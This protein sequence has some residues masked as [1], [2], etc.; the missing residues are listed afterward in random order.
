MTTKP[1]TNAEHSAHTR[2]LLIKAGRQEFS[3]W[4]YAEASTERIVE[5]AGV[6]RGALYHHYRDKRELFEAVVTELQ[7][8]IVR[9]I[10]QRATARRDVFAGLLAGCDAWLDACLD[11]EVRRILLLD[12]PAVLG[13]ERWTEIDAEHGG[14]SLR[15]GIDACIEA[16]EL[17][18]VDAASLTHLLTGAMNHAALLMARSDDVARLR[19]E[20]GRTL[21]A[22]L[23]G[24][25][26]PRD[27]ARTTRQR[28]YSGGSRGSTTS[29][30]TRRTRRRP[31]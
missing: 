4:G 30:T 5:A 9:R 19:R 8:E 18:G 26:R 10:D 25:R 24:L 20:T 17:A 27:G 2:G 31:R 14:G 11:P 3:R 22:L 15:Q 23:R 1:R 28:S 13:S 6:T 12:G 16:G 29:A 7:R 21:H